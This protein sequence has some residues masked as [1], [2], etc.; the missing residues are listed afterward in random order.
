MINR[1]K[2]AYARRS[3]SVTAFA[4]AMVLLSFLAPGARAANGGATANTWGTAASLDGTS[5][6]MTAVSSLSVN[7]VPGFTVEAWVKP[8]TPTFQ[9]YIVTKEDGTVDSQFSLYMSSQWVARA[10]GYQE[11][12]EFDVR[13]GATCTYRSTSDYLTG[14]TGAAVTSW[15][16]IAAVVDSAGTMTVFVNGVP[17]VNSNSVTGTCPSSIPVMIGARQV[18]GGTD[19]Y[20]PGL[21]DEVRISNVARYTADFTPSAA[22]FINDA[23]TLMLYHLDKSRARGGFDDSSASGYTLTPSSTITFVKY[24]R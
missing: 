16:H 7:A 18:V 3:L 17:S 10:G 22:P 23:N 1:N 19:G 24:K 11:T 14:M 13:D 12:F 6:Y 9:A 8:S 15:Q 20:F 2:H 4:V 5:A 21:I